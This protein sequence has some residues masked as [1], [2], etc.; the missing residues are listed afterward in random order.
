MEQLKRFRYLSA[1]DEA[2]RLEL[3]KLGY[4]YR[5]LDKKNYQIFVLKT[6]PPT[7]ESEVDEAFEAKFG[8][9]HDLQMALRKNMEQLEHG[10]KIIDG[11]KEQH[12]AAGFIDITAEDENGN[13]VVIELKAGTAGRETIGQILGYMGCLQRSDKPVR[14]IIVAEDFT[15]SAETAVG[16]ATNLQ[17]KKYGF[18][19][20]F[21]SAGIGKKSE[22]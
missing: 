15:V 2:G 13:T 11:G 20:S 10:L 4:A 9:E 5:G 1:G 14:G 16:A 6:A 21:S 19:F 8:L 22:G 12:V 17:L 3:E 18:K 7:G